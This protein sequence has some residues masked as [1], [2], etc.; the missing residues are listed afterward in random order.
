MAETEK[1]FQYVLHSK[2]VEVEE[3]SSRGKIDRAKLNWSGEEGGMD[4]VDLARLKDYLVAL[5]NS[6]ESDPELI[7]LPGAQKKHF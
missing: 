7:Q 4:V 2:K 5:N 3:S 1:H 6:F